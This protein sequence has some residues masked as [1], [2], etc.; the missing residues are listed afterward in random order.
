MSTVDEAP[1]RL[2]YDE[3]DDAVLDPSTAILR[4]AELRMSGYVEANGL[5]IKRPRTVRSRA[6]IP[7]TLVIEPVQSF[8]FNGLAEGTGEVIAGPFHPHQTGG[9]IEGV[10]PG[11]LIVEGASE[12]RAWFETT[13]LIREGDVVEFRHS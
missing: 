10:I 12:P 5:F 9:R 8:G 3:V 1:V 2:A 11:D 7:V 13:A 6:R 4:G